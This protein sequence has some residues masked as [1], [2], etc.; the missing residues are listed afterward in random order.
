MNASLAMIEAAKPKDEIEAALAAQMAAT[1]TAAMAVLAKL[2][3]A[4]ATERRVA[5]FGSAAAR[6]CCLRSGISSLISTLQNLSACTG[7]SARRRLWPVIMR[8]INWRWGIVGMWRGYVA[9]YQEK[10]V[11]HFLICS[12]MAVFEPEVLDLIDPN[13][14]CGIS[15][16]IKAALAHSFKVAH[17]TH[18]AFWVDVNDRDALRRAE[19]ELSRRERSLRAPRLIWKK[20]SSLAAG[21]TM[22][23]HHHADFRVATVLQAVSSARAVDHDVPWPNRELRSVEGHVGTARDD[24]IDFLVIERMSVDP[25]FRINRH[26]SEIDEIHPQIGGLIRPLRVHWSTPVVRRHLLERGLLKA[27][28]PVTVRRRATVL[29][30][31][32]PPWSWCLTHQNNDDCQ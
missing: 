19:T 2:D 17:W 7:S 13:R 21:N 23:N 20:R 30:H 5:A 9:D 25:D 11:K 18:G 22:L 29:V 31:A 6:W 28:V 16:L 14:P 10:P 3:V 26:Y 24:H 8:P 1:H 4:F 32:A 12:G 27:E 15:D